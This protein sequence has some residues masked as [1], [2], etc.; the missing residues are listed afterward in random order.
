[1]LGRTIL[2]STVSSKCSTELRRSLRAIIEGSVH[3]A[4]NRNYLILFE[5]G[6][7]TVVSWRLVLLINKV[8]SI[9][10]N[11][12]FSFGIFTWCLNTFVAHKFWVRLGCSRWQWTIFFGM[13]RRRWKVSRNSLVKIEKVTYF[14]LQVE[15]N[16]K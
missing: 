13:R 6:F 15:I 2:L 8:L 4:F 7:L 12:W 9:K 16:S 1:M 10:A 11:K 3:F 5:S 14:M